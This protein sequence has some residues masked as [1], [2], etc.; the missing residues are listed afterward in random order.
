[1][2]ISGE[3]NRRSG[4]QTSDHR[5]K[6]FLFPSLKNSCTEHLIADRKRQYKRKCRYQRPHQIIRLFYIRKGQLCEKDRVILSP[7]IVIDPFCAVPDI[8]RRKLRAPHHRLHE[9]IIHEFFRSVGF[10]METGQIGPQQEEQQKQRLLLEDQ[11]HI[12]HFHLYFF[13]AIDPAD[14]KT[15]RRHPDTGQAHKLR[16]L[17]YGQ[18]KNKKSADCNAEYFGKQP[19]PIR[20]GCKQ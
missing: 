5:G 17:A 13:K 10:R 3:R 20:V 9:S 18:G 7:V 2:H 1:M 4:Q 16:N 15:D 6:L 12:R 8:L 19:S 14:Q 11:I